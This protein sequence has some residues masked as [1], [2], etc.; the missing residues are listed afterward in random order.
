VYYAIPKVA[1]GPD[2]GG[3]A[4]MKL[5]IRDVEGKPR[6]VGLV[7]GEGSSPY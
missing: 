7:T 6:V 2:K 4:K 5:L 1:A 3:R